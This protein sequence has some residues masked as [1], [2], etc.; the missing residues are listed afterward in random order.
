[1]CVIIAKKIYDKLNDEKRFA[2]FKFRDRGYN[3]SYEIKSYNYKNI[4]VLYLKDKKSQWI[5]GINDKGIAIVSAALDNHSDSSIG[6]TN[7]PNENFK[8]Y[9]K[10][11]NIRNSQILKMAL[12]QTS[13]DDA[14]KVLVDSKF[15]GNTFLT[16]GYKLYSLEIALPQSKL[17]QYQE[18]EEIS[19]NVD[20]KTFLVK[21]MQN[22]DE[23]DFTV[24]VKDESNKNLLVKTNHSID[25]KDLGYVKGQNGYESSI[26]RRKIV[27]NILK[28]INLNIE[29]TLHLLHTLGD[30]SLNKNPELLPLRCKE[31]TLLSKKEKEKLGITDYYTTD[32]LAFYRT[33]MYIMPLHSKIVNLDSMKLIQKETDC[34]LIILKPNA[35]KETIIQIKN[36]KEAL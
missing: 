1:M 7:K 10:K 25:K 14:L 34:H 15:I 26:N 27:Y 11:V 31:K 5:E 13:I 4:S 18:D 6:N 35:L 2:L 36:H 16:D 33:N 21:V 12:R 28:N 24:S 22:L 30:P 19:S 9:L 3:P 20:F 29:D 23:K 17:L 8:K 32:L